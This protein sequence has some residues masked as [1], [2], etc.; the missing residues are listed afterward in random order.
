MVIMHIS[1]CL[2]LIQYSVMKTW[3]WMSNEKKTKIYI[4]AGVPQGELECNHY[5][6]LCYNK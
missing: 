6:H 1:L 4:K 5:K 2:K 3:F